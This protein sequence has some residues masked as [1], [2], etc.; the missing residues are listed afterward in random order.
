MRQARLVQGMAVALLAT[1][2]GS[3]TKLPQ[4]PAGGALTASTVSVTVT[5]N[6]QATVGRPVTFMIDDAGT[7]VTK[8]QVTSTGGSSE[9]VEITGTLFDAGGKPIGD[10]SGGAINLSPGASQLVEMTGP[11][12]VGTIS[13]VTFE[14]TTQRSP[15]P[16]TAA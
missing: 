6:A 12:P 4:A 2:C 16:T 11:A 7:L 3:T 9:S 10:V 8:A 1:G 15:T 14:V 5:G 13:S